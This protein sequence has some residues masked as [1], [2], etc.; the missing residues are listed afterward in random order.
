MSVQ[1]PSASGTRPARSSCSSSWLGVSLPLRGCA[2]SSRGDT[3]TCPR[4][5]GGLQAGPKVS[6]G[7][8][9][10]AKKCM[11]QGLCYCKCLKHYF[12]KRSLL[13]T[14]HPAF[15]TF[16][17]SGLRGL[18][19]LPAQGRPRWPWASCS[20][21]LSRWREDLQPTQIKKATDL[22]FVAILIT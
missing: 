18:R 10:D 20:P 9:F 12:V 11:K 4:N 5:P 14:I 2:P 22:C 19:G 15:D 13:F 3:W 6:R 16:K 1:V 7:H 21:P 8:C 17:W